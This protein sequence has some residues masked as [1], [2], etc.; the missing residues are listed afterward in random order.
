M[1]QKNFEEWI[2]NNRENLDTEQPDKQ[3]FDD[4][5]NRI[6]NDEKKQRIQQFLLIIVVIILIFSIGWFFSYNK[7]EHTEPHIPMTEQAIAMLKLTNESS[8]LEQLFT[9]KAREISQIPLNG[10]TTYFNIYKQQIEVIDSQIKIYQE[11]YLY[12]NSNPEMLQH[13]L[14]LHKHKL[15]VLQKLIIEMNRFNLLKKS[16]NHEKESQFITI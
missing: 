11:E 6:I 9:V 14:V 12:N 8:P 1:K 10:D 3:V 15:E 2:K 4:L 16:V 13:I 7:K 5:T